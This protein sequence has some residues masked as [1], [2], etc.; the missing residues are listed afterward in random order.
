M[1]GR[2][3]AVRVIHLSLPIRLAVPSL[4]IS[5][6]PKK[7]IGFSYERG[8]TGAS[9]GAT[10]VAG[11]ALLGALLFRQFGLLGVV[12][13]AWLMG[14]TGALILFNFAMGLAF[15]KPLC[16]GCR[17]LPIIREH[18]ALHIGGAESDVAIWNSVRGKYTFEGLSL[19]T[20][21]AICRF[22]PI[23]KRLKEL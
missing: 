22:C 2:A 16:T 1:A 20:D 15:V 7:A 3:G 4:L 10:L 19:G 17:L 21:P 23:A 11:S 13:S 18:E 5:S 9:L 8:A 14:T 12:A 6:L